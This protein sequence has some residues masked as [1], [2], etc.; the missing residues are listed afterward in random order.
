MTAT[1]PRIVSADDHIVEPPD[2]WTSRLPQRY[3]QIGPRIEYHPTGVVEVVDGSYVERPGPS[4]PLVPWWVY[5]DKYSAIKRFVAAAGNDAYEA[6]T[7]A[8]DWDE[9]R[10]G[11][12]QPAARLAD[13]DINGV[14]ASLCFPSYPRFCGQI[15]MEA[16]DRDLALAC[17]K[18]YN[19]WMVDEW[20]AGSG[21]RLVPLCLIPLWD[22]ELAAQEVRR[23][24]ARGVSAVAFSEIP[25][26][27]GLPSI[28]SGYW[29]PFYR[30]C[31]ETRT[32][33]CMHVGSGT[34]TVLTSPDAPHAV[35]ALMLFANS[36]AGLAD[37]LMSGLFARF[38][39]LRL[40]YAECQIGWLP[41][42]LQ[43]A[44]EIWV[45]H[46]WAHDRTIPELPSTY[47]RGRVFSCFF[48]DA[49]GVETLDHIGQD[50][51][52]FETDY[53]HND[54]T[55]PHSRSVAADLF[56]H[57]DQ[58][59]VDKICRTNAIDLFGL[60]FDRAS[61]AGVGAS[62]TGVRSSSGPSR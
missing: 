41:Y 61:V 10:P 5:E 9:M 13:M 27:L 58:H 36:A 40:M 25:P 53:P 47:Y 43:R 37:V 46:L 4:G 55:W 50:Q 11:C 30:A 17:V 19:D 60:P 26:W 32:V 56:G 39:G 38:P 44:D 54:G 29:D 23:N 6:D 24:A 7:S 31:E 21:G 45:E 59:V 16:R 18:A 20:C 3:Q 51:V 2:I 34:R 35:A 8:I 49:V 57:L 28:H 62:N 12:W 48:K 52:L 1:I 14:E 33:V 15:F 22:A 42:L